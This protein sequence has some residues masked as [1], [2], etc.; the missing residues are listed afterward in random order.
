MISKKADKGVSGVFLQC[1]NSAKK[2]VDTTLDRVVV[3]LLRSGRLQE[4]F[5]RGT[6]P[7]PFPLSRPDKLSLVDREDIVPDLKSS[8]MDNPSPGHCTVLHGAAGQGKMDVALEAALQLREGKHLPGGIFMVDCKGM[9]PSRAR[10]T[11]SMHPL[12]WWLFLPQQPITIHPWGVQGCT[13]VVQNWTC[14]RRS[15]VRLSPLS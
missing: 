10:K 15:Q 1:N 14:W 4:G 8:L 5:R 3:V 13:E 9:S 11:W 12:G 7:L 2:L 6:A